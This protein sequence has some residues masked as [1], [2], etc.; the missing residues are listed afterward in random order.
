MS[1]FQVVEHQE[2]LVGA[3]VAIHQNS[4]VVLDF[5]DEARDLTSLTLAELGQLL[6]D[7]GFAHKRSLPLVEGFR[8]HLCQK[9]LDIRI[10]RC[11]S[12]LIASFLVH[13]EQDHILCNFRK[14]RPNNFRRE[15]NRARKS[16]TSYLPPILSP[17]RVLVKHKA[18]PLLHDIKEC[19]QLG[20]ADM[21]FGCFL[22]PSQTRVW[23]EKNNHWFTGG[24]KNLFYDVLKIGTTFGFRVFPRV[25]QHFDFYA[26]R[27]SEAF[28]LS[29]IAEVF[30]HLQRNPFR[31]FGL[32]KDHP[33]NG[34]Y[35]ATA[36]E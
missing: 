12:Y 32:V 9:D 35:P 15:A 11:L 16:L 25:I 31:R 33:E 14:L 7:F 13:D 34:F 10:E 26:G 3:P 5:K 28:D 30:P 24:S 23:V 18:A 2:P 36:Q 22:V 6:D 19:S 20:W 27:P 4:F 21:F 8:K 17:L 29:N 1:S